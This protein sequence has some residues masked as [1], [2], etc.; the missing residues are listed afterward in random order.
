MGIVLDRRKLQGELL[1]RR[2][3]VPNFCPVIKNRMTELLYFSSQLHW[4][5]KRPNQKQP[6]REKKS[7]S[8]AV[9]D[10]P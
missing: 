7:V 6:N 9:G 4:P 2:G 8:H 1:L 5:S 10:Y 3:E